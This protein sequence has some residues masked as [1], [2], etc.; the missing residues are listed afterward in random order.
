MMRLIHIVKFIYLWAP[1]NYCKHSKFVSFQTKRFY[2]SVTSLNDGNTDPEDIY[3]GR[4][5]D[6]FL[7]VKKCHFDILP[8]HY[9]DS[10]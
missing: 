9:S 1:T 2:Y 6:K 4:T 7:L 3:H 10:D 5:R 8:I